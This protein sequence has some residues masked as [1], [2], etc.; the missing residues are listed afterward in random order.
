[1]MRQHREGKITLS[2]ALI[3]KRKN[4]IVAFAKII[5]LLFMIN[6]S[7][8]TEWN[9]NYTQLNSFE[10][11]R[12]ASELMTNG[13]ELRKHA[14][15]SEEISPFFSCENVK[16]A[17][18]Y[19]MNIH[20]KFYEF[21]NDIALLPKESFDI[22]KSVKRWERI[23]NSSCT[24]LLC[25]RSQMMFNNGIGSLNEF[26]YNSTNGETMLTDWINACQYCGEESRNYK[27][28][29]LEGTCQPRDSIAREMIL[30]FPRSILYCGYTIFGFP[31][32]VN[33]SQIVK[34]SLLGTYSY[35]CSCV[36]SKSFGPKCTFGMNDMIANLITRIGV[37]FTHFIL[38]VIIF[39]A[40]FIPKLGKV[41]KTK[42]FAN[43]I[44][45]SCVVIGFLFQIIAS[46]QILASDSYSKTTLIFAALS[47]IISIFGLFAWIFGLYRIVELARARKITISVR[48]CYIF[49]GLLFFTVGIISPIVASVAF[50][51]DMG[52]FQMFYYIYLSVFS[53]AALCGKFQ[54]NLKINMKNQV[55]ICASLYTHRV[56]KQLSDINLVQTNVS[57]LIFWNMG[58]NDTCSMLDLSFSHQ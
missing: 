6:K 26:I 10:N 49:L 17:K 55:F 19:E 13:A 25:D 2:P 28:R 21:I 57:K 1:M 50:P 47:N 46:V 7:S 14:L 15:N 22:C 41:V 18:Y 56:M 31:I 32:L 23:M 30:G 51:N 39:F 29:I 16:L 20:V 27:R 37:T 43:L 45:T 35:I 4:I 12:N 40:G 11:C 42:R 44:P 8:T 24:E 3:T 54:A 9:E 33:N 38:S 36:E 34:S 53:F 58:L 5:V 52:Q 48:V